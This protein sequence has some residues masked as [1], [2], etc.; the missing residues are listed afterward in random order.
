MKISKSKLSKFHIIYLGI[1]IIPFQYL[2]NYA[3]FTSV[4]IGISALSMVTLIRKDSILTLTNFIIGYLILIIFGL[5]STFYSGDP[6]SS[7][8][9]LI[10]IIPYYFYC[11]VLSWHILNIPSKSLDRIVIS[12]ITFLV[13]TIIISVLALINELEG[14]NQWTRIGYKTFN[15]QFTMFTYYLMIG[16]SI[17]TWLLYKQ[18][19][20]FKKISMCITLSFLYIISVLTAIRKA[21]IIPV[22][23]WVVFVYMVSINKKR[24][25]R[26]IV[27]LIA[28]FTLFMLAY[29]LL[30]NNEYFASTVGRRIEGFIAGLQGTG[31]ADNSF[32]VRQQLVISAIECFKTY[33]IGGYGFGAFRDYADKMIG[34]NLYAHNNYVELLAS[35]GII[36]FSIYYGC[37]IL[38]FNKLYTRFK[39][40]KNPIYILGIAFLISLLVNDFAVVSYL[41][42][43]Y[44][45]MLTI[46]SCLGHCRVNNNQET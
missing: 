14:F 5:I 32:N 36:G 26:G 27:I 45:V 28:G 31:E 12:L 9:I 8:S 38:I 17:S 41:S 34:V 22:I 25:I 11:F 35:S 20:K 1:F 3:I 21:I 33:P 13:S 16:L 24:I 39:I 6:T 46:L 2:M 15:D 10:Q 44:M 43:P 19:S 30:L 37:V 40:N 29:S 4:L 18:T 23:F 42:L 7:Y